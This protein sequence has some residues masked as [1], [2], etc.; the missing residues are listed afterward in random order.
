M[1]ET[2]Q[3][4]K[5]DVSMSQDPTNQV[6]QLNFTFSDTV[7]GYVTWSDPGAGIFRL[8]TT[9]GRE[10]QVTLTPEAYGEVIRNLGEPWQ[11]PGDRLENLLQP[12]RYMFAY[13]VFYPEGRGVSFEA[14]HLVFVGRDPHEF[15]FE[16]QD[17][18][19]NQVRQLA[20]FYL[21]AQFPD[22]NIDF[23][24]Y[25]TH[26]T[27]EG[28]KIDSSRQE[29]DTISRMIYGFATAYLL[30]GDD[31]YLEVAERG[32]EYLRLHM[33]A[34]AG[35]DA[36]YWYHGIDV[37][38]THER[39]IL[40]SEFGDDYDAIP[41]YEQIYALAGP[42]QTMRVT[43]DPRIARDA[44]LTCNLFDR[45][46][47]DREQGGYFSHIDP[48]NLD[49][50]DASLTHNR[51]RK[52]WNSI[53]DHAPAFLINLY[54]ATGEQRWA[55]MLTS[56]ADLIAK[57]MPDYDNSP[58]MQEKFH[59]DWSPDHE[60]PLQKNR[61]IVGHNLKVAWNLL[62]IHSMTPNEEYVRFARRIAEEMPKWGMDKQRGGL[63][64]MVERD[65][66][67]GE[68]F[69]RLIWHDRKAW[70]QQEQAILAYLI[71]AGVLGDA[72]YVRY[73]REF[74]SFYNAWFPDND[75]GGV[76]FNALASG[77]PYL[78]G[79]ERLKG[80]HS[81]SGYH[82]FELCYLAAVYGNLLITKQPMDFYF[83]P[84]PGALQDNILRVAPDLLPAGSVRI[85]EVW[86]NGQ[87][88]TDFDPDA[89]TVR[90]PELPSAAA[91]PLQYRPAW[92]GNPRLLPNATI[93]ELRVHVRLIPVGINFDLFVESDADMT[94][95]T[96][97]GVIDDVA[98]PALKVHLDK[99]I[100]TRPKRL[101]IRV[102][103]LQSICARAVRA[104]AF[105]RSKMDLEEDIF[106][107][108]ANP[109]VQQAI[110]ETGYWEQIVPLNEFDRA[111]ITRSR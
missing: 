110:Q 98:E 86:V 52:N 69:H 85:G 104:I 97:N 47:L 56:V 84:Q 50:R 49:P 21:R 55:D 18:W 40:A 111:V 53:G 16:S 13:G 34:K 45:Y 61:A 7:G 109:D 3:E 81:M 5:G 64:D 22:G 77:I 92:A 6:N 38:D 103:E 83:K 28:Q 4:E 105:S 32:T 74:S 25:R 72:D 71:M 65:R 19:I 36:V 63:Y 66:R 99:V 51:A 62:R 73:A 96:I 17:W 24:Q 79:T 70:W 23:S 1:R 35:Q 90:L 10:Y 11:D 59:E 68:E 107:V 2:L 44:E 46:F 95:L 75:S 9:D 91:H 15:R 80:S 101:V 108:G 58:F 43:G 12:G 8:Q 102:E 54:L 87:P 39:K 42:I 27:I 48:V 78:L 33:Q 37:H 57:H 67:P 82:S 89:L 41:A 88:Y 94:I 106:V 93:D 26:L 60:T 31:R 14:K 76:Y 100:A 29:T 20:E 30:T